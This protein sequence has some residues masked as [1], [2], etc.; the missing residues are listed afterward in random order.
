MYIQFS[1]W[2]NG[3]IKLSS[4]LRYPSSHLKTWR[5]MLVM[6]NHNRR[7]AGLL[8]V[9]DARLLRDIPADSLPVNL[10]SLSRSSEDCGLRMQLLLA[11]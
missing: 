8:A 6:Q 11:P 5:Q 4:I 10:A 3:Q 1:D 9:L 7:A 2:L